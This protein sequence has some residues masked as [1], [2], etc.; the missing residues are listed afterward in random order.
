MLRLVHPALGGQGTDPPVRRKG[1]RSPALSLT[2]EE[3]RHV[4]A[5]LKNTARAY[6]GNEVL[7][8]VLGITRNA[9]NVAAGNRARL[10]SGTFAIRLARA[11]GV[12]VEAILTG[13]LTAAGRCP[14]CGHRAGDG[15]IVAGGER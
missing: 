1:T 11:A 12:A 4:R 7:A 15:R 3:V 9:L 5:A 13:A 6:G 8:A 14:T 10:L 2:H